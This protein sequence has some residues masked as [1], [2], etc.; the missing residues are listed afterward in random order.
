VFLGVTA[1]DGSQKHVRVLGALV[2][3]IRAE[4]E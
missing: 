2:L 1:V 4:G 3:N